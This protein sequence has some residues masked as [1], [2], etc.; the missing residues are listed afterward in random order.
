MGRCVSESSHPGHHRPTFKPA[1]HTRWRARLFAIAHGPAADG[2]GTNRRDKSRTIDD[3][4]KR[5][6]VQ[7]RSC[8][9]SSIE[10]L[11]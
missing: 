10:V 9:A 11:Q 2:T 7:T 8:N 1:I 3:R 6:T 5:V 4:A